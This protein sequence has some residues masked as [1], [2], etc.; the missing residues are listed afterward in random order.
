MRNY[1]DSFEFKFQWRSYQDKLLKSFD[2]HISDDH[3]H[4]IAPPGSGKT[5]LGIEIV[6]RLGKKALVF[7]PTLAIRNQWKQRIDTFFLK[8][9]T[10]NYFSF[11]VKEPADI[12]FITYQSLFSF[13]KS[14][15]DKEKY[16]AFFKEHQI[17][18]LVLDEAHHLKNEWWNCLI[19]LKNSS[20]FYV[21]ALTATPPYDS[22]KTELSKYFEL[23]G[24]IDD[25]I[26]VPNLVKETDLSPHQDFVY[27]SKPEDVA[28]NFI[29]EFRSKIANFKD[30]LLADDTFISILKQHRFYKN[31]EMYFEELYSNTKYF[32]SIVIFL[33][34]CGILIESEKLEVLGFNKNEKITF[35]SLELEWLEI[36]LQN[37]LVE[38]REQ[39]LEH[40]DYLLNLEKQLRKLNVFEKKR[41]NFIGNELLYKS[42]AGSPSKLK[43]IVDVVNYELENLKENLSCVILTDYIRKEF[44]NIEDDKVTTINKIGAVPIF[45]YLRTSIPNVSG[46]A[47]LTGSIVVVHKSVTNLVKENGFSFTPLKNSSEFLL[48]SAKSKST[49]STVALVTELFEEGVIKILIGTKSLLGEGWDAPSINTLILASFVGSFVSSNQMRG[50]AIRKD[51]DKPN[52]TGNIWHLVSLDTSDVNGGRDIEILKRRFD[53]FVGVSNTENTYIETG[54]ERLYLP[55]QIGTK[56]IESIN[57]N[58]FKRAKDRTKTK[59]D[60]N[61]A[62]IKGGELVKQTRYFYQGKKSFKKQRQ[63]YVFDV[64]RYFVVELLLGML[65]FYIEFFLQSINML[66]NKGI[67][68][69][70]YA[71]IAAFI[72]KF[73]RNL[74][75]A[76]VLY[77][78]HGYLDKKINKMGLVILDTMYELGLMTTNE[79]LVYVESERFDNGDVMCDLKGATLFENALFSNALAQLLDP[80]E[81]PRYLIVK[82]NPFRKNLDIENFYPIPDIFGDKKKHALVFQQYWEHY[83]GKNRLIYTRTKVGRKLLLKARLFHVHNAFKKTTKKVV[84]WR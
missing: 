57:Y 38:D 5:I 39:L 20:E 6:R 41:V 40:E 56:K 58:T 63:L 2:N 83:L 82:T 1:C 84:A 10:Y 61:K 8:D 30:Q 44:L 79:F 31:P 50:R 29:V 51:P 15:D 52:K 80:V 64:V 53:A 32:S 11:D 27:F 48:V 62:I 14:F 19:S 7:A 36:L 23:C 55:E 9:K 46:L 18:T 22:S 42:L 24:E 47:L 4:V 67:T 76:L 13:Y 72:F 16:H 35:P 66:F 60:W 3:F 70:L 65:M 37:I 59:E 33:N 73:G 49:K 26:A 34:A 45:H 43:S 12:T 54:F 71:F 69:L 78:K 77:I 74:Y 17:E 28:I 68:Y 81:S 25:E 21:V 75:K